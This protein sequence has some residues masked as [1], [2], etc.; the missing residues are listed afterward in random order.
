MLNKNLRKK[1][2]NFS[3]KSNLEII[4]RSSLINEAFKNDF[5]YSIGESS[6]FER[7]AGYLPIK[8]D[9]SF[10]VSQPCIRLGDFN[11]EVKN[12]LPNHLA[13]FEMADIGG[14]HLLKNKSC[15]QNREKIIKNGY[16]FLVNILGIDPEALYI[17]YFSGNNLKTLSDDKVKNNNKYIEADKETVRVWKELGIS[18]D[19]F[20]PDSTQKTFVLTFFPFEFYAGYRSEIFFKKSDQPYDLVEIATFE[21]LD[22]QT[23]LN[24]NNQLMDICHLGGC[25][26]GMAVGVE[27]LLMV[28]NSFNDIF[29]CDHIFPL[30][31]NILKL[32]KNKNDS[33]ARIVT[34]A[35]R[36]LSAIIVEV[37][38][39][40]SGKIRERSRRRK[41][42]KILQDA[43]DNA[44]IL[45]LDF[46][47]HWQDLFRLNARLQPWYYTGN[48]P[49][50]TIETL[51][52]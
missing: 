47:K 35:V 9:W 19:H 17:N 38:S 5:N 3:Q 41:M 50:P 10:S 34:E 24:E 2:R 31:K 1:I 7:F 29:Q 22:F 45:K 44:E 20:I 15:V 14:L 27:R 28:V 48:I 36:L 32:S 21:F 6:I 37:G 25:F 16:N 26:S 42:K 13:L 4:K 49:S 8:K 33:A 46:K 40:P 12:N 51:E 39:L 11:K 23:K 52:K 30:Y 43:Y 18:D